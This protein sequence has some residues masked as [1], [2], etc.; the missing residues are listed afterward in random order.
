MSKEVMSPKNLES[1]TN[2]RPA[3]FALEQFCS[4]FRVPDAITMPFDVSLSD[5]TS[6]DMTQ[7]GPKVVRSTLQAVQL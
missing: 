6:T 4:L 3:L 1:Q 2:F 7:L 5:I